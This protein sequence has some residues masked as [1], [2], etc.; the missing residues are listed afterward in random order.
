MNVPGRYIGFGVLILLGLILALSP[1]DEARHMKPDNDDLIAQVT[2]NSDQ[3]PPET[4]ADWIINKDPGYQIIDL[5][6]EEDFNTYH[7]PTSV[8]IP[9]AQ[10]LTDDGLAQLDPRR[11]TVLASNGMADAGRAWLLLRQ[12]GYKN[13]YVLSGGLNYW[14]DVFTNPDPPQGAYADEELFKYQFRKS[15]GPLMMG[16]AVVDSAETAPT[17]EPQQVPEFK[18]RPK[19]QRVDQGC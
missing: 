1:V 7:I 5:R 9:L 8:H 10:L 12:K 17:V 16:E 19:K 11:V 13:T 4:V 18:P 2:T 14:V 3:I 6:S 15:A